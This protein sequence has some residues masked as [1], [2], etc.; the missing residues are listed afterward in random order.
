LS[1]AALWEAPL[2]SNIIVFDIECKLRKRT[3]KKKTYNISRICKERQMEWSNAL[4]ISLR[5]TT[6]V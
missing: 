4:T 6:S 2:S 3:I 5:D 1:S